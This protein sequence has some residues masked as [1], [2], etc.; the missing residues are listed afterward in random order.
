MVEDDDGEFWG[1]G[2]CGSTWRKK[3]NFMAEI[4]AI[5]EKYPYRQA[6]YQ[7]SGKNWLPADPGAEPDD[8]ED[9]V[10]EE[11]PDESDEYERG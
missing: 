3:K 7:K 8:Y 1:C 5:V 6:C 9:R 2:E 11:T 4:T 10:E